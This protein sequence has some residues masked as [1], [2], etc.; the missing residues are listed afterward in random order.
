MTNA[1]LQDVQRGWKVFAGDQEVGT[2]AEVSADELTVT[3]GTFSRHEYRVPADCVVEA[4]EGVVDL[5]VDAAALA[6]FEVTA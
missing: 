1:V 2:V 5:A 4:S 6:G 3:K